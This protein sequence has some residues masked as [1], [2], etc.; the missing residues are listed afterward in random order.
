MTPRTR[1]RTGL[2]LSTRPT[3][4][5]ADAADGSTAGAGT[6]GSA[7]PSATAAKRT[8]GAPAAK[9][10]GKLLD[11]F[12]GGQALVADPFAIRAF[13]PAAVTGTPEEQL[14]ALE[15]AIE[16]A[17]AAGLESIHRARFRGEVEIG[18]LLAEIRKRELHLIKHGTIEEYGWERW[19]YRRS[20]LYELMDTAPIRL[21]VAQGVASGNPDTKER[22]A[23]EAG[24]DGKRPKGGKSAEA[25]QQPEIRAELSKSVALALLPVWRA[26]DGEHQVADL[27]GAAMDRATGRGAKMTAADV[28]GVRKDRGQTV[29]DDKLLPS[30]QEKREAVDRALANAAATAERLVETVAALM[31]AGTPP[32][33]AE[34][35]ERHVK[36]ITVAGKWLGRR[37]Q[38]PAEIIDAEIVN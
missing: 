38:V 2:N 36:A 28:R 29:T 26:E 6:E 17:Q 13:D 30:E 25:Q 34:A 4:K 1:N 12:G 3:G 9:P 23:I 21:A 24:P 18:L 10:K 14:A 22:K 20:T 5:P 7:P 19:G 32:L 27:L 33:D 31:K 15:S 11:N 16:A 37:T 35:A 8:G